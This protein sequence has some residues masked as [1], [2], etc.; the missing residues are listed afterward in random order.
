MDLT[1]IP[2]IHTYARFIAN[3]QTLDAYA[4]PSITSEEPHHPTDHPF[5]HSDP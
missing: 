3:I 1:N 2:D 4:S 5:A